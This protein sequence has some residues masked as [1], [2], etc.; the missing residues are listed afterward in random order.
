MANVGKIYKVIWRNI[1]DSESGLTWH[2]HLLGTYVISQNE[3]IT[4]AEVHSKAAAQV[5]DCLLN[6]KDWMECRGAFTYFKPQEEGAE[7]MQ[8]DEGRTQTKIALNEYLLVTE[9]IITVVSNMLVIS[10][11]LDG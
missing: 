8:G 9:P 4:P 2:E 5:M 10:S 6:T 1:P 11:S 7:A 3:E